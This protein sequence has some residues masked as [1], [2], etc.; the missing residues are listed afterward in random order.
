M[1]DGYR[2]KMYNQLTSTNLPNILN[3]LPSNNF[4]K[5]SYG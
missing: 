5:D 3:L 1:L 2:Q 4:G